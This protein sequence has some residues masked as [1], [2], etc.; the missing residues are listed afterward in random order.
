MSQDRT[1]EIDFTQEEAVLQVYPQ[2]PLL[3]SKNL[4]WQGI[5]LSHYWQPPHE[6][7]E[8]QPRQCL[9]SIHLGQPVT[10]GQHWQDGLAINEFQ[11][12]GDV[13]I[14]PATRSLSETWN[15]DAEFFEIYLAPTLFSQVAYELVDGEHLE[16]LPQPN[17]RDP[18]IH[19]L[20]LSLKSELESTEIET[21]DI[22]KAHDRLL[23]ESMSAVLAIH[24]M[25]YYSSRKPVL[26]DYSDGLPKYK[27][28]IAIDYIQSHLN[29]DISL[30]KLSQ[31]VGM[32]VHHFSRLFKQSLGCSPYQYVLKCRIE[33]AKR[34]LLQRQLSIAEVAIAVGF[35]SQSHFTQH[36]KRLI[37]ATPKQFIN[38][39]P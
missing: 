20:G 9:I 33:R 21:S 3:S 25:K 24:L 17:I 18:L 11:R 4:S 2:A 1:L 22:V 12:Y 38:Q 30:D 5:H 10:I 28:Q 36:F 27:L 7:P 29:S 34:L 6:T 15:A 23:V 39:A 35:S 19:Q 13:S 16:V 26:R 14:Y 37:G 31:E 8:Y 32:S